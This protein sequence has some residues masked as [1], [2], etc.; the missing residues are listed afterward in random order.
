MKLNVDYFK[1]YNSNQKWCKQKK[2]QR[3]ITNIRKQKADITT[4][5]PGSKSIISKY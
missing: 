5:D 3:E 2:E 1:R 4:H